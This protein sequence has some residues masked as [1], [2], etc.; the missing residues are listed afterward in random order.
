MAR[1]CR[2]RCSCTGCARRTAHRPRTAPAS[3]GPDEVTGNLAATAAQPARAGPFPAGSLRGTVELADGMQLP[4]ATAIPANAPVR[5]VRPAAAT[6]VV[7][8]VRGGKPVPRAVVW[9]HTW[10][11]ATPAPDSAARFRGPLA[12][13]NELTD[14]HGVARLAV[15]A[16]ELAVLVT[17]PLAG[18]EGRRLRVEPGSTVALELVLP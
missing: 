2:R 18:H 17:R 16:G 10:L 9:A 5:I 12:S 14:E 1:G 3:W 11:G 6:L 13:T 7:T 8:I 15:A 4:L